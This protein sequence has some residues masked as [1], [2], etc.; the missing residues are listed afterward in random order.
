MRL[1]F[2]VRDTGI[3]FPADKKERIFNAFEQADGSMSR[4]YGG[5]GLGLAISSRFC[6]MMGGKIWVESEVGK[7]STFH[8]TIRLG[9]QG[10]GEAK[11]LMEEESSLKGLAILVV[12]DNA[13]NRKILEQI[14]LYWEMKPTVVER[15]AAGLLAMEKALNEG[16]PFPVVITD[17][18]MPEMDG[19]ELV[20]LIKQNPRFATSAIVM[21]T[22]SG[23]RG[24]G[25]AA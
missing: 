1:H 11:Q 19:F 22:S 25:R 15:A 4:K 12:D 23:E 6:Q 3:G 5:T 10:H 7:G 20:E 14:L 17:C 16:N 2:S 9:L 8:F 21:L 13:T 18:M 24:D